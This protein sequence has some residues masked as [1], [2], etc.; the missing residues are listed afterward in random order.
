MQILMN[1]FKDPNLKKKHMKTQNEKV[2]KLAI[3]QYFFNIHVSIL[4]D[5]VI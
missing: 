4:N 2:I 5:N 3:F 1:I